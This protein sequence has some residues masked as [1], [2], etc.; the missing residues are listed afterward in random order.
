MLDRVMS[1]SKLD[2]LE[3]EINVESF[4][5]IIWPAFQ[6]GKLFSPYQSCPG[7]RFCAEGG[8]A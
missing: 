1:L 3:E 6:V 7:N 4:E 5:R 2:C 8:K